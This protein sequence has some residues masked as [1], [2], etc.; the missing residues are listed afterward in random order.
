MRL[1]HRVRTTATPAQ[2]WA[3]L[4][5][6]SAWPTFELLLRGVRGGRSRVTPGER[7]MALARLS[8]LAVPVDVVEVVPEQRLVLLVHTGPG[9]REVL[10]FDLV[11]AVPRGTDIRLSVSVE[12]AFAVGAFLPLWLANGLS[13]RVLAAVTDRQAR[14]GRRAAA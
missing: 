1:E 9:L 13:A 12:G 3:V 10:A 2:V 8:L 11:E 7:L 4:G 6:P 14:Q 5:N